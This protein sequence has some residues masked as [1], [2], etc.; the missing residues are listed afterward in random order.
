MKKLINIIVILFLSLNISAQFDTRTVSTSSGG[1]AMSGTYTIWYGNNA[2]QILKPFIICEGFDP[3]NNINAAYVRDAQ[4]GSTFCNA[5]WNAGFDVIVLNLNNNPMAIEKNADLF[6]A[7]INTINA[8]L[9]TNQSYHRLNVLGVSM[10][11]LVIR[12][13]LAKMEQQG[14]DHRVENYISFDSPQLGA[15]VPLGLQQMLDTYLGPLIDVA[16]LNS[17]LDKLDSNGLRDKME[18]LS[19][20]VIGA[21]IHNFADYTAAFEMSACYMRENVLRANFLNNLKSVGDFPHNC[22]NIAIS[23]GA[24]TVDQGFGQGTELLGFNQNYTLVNETLNLPWGLGSVGFKWTPL[25]IQNEVN[26]MKGDRLGRTF[27]ASFQVQPSLNDISIGPTYA[28]FYSQH[29]L[30]VPANDL[31]LD[32]AP[33]SYQTLQLSDMQDWL[34][35]RVTIPIDLSYKV[36]MKIPLIGFHCTTVGKKFDITFPRSKIFGT[37]TTATGTTDDTKFRFC[38]VPT[39]SALA[40][41][42]SNWFADIKSIIPT[43]PYPR[44][45]SVTPFDAICFSSTNN[46]H[47]FMPDQTDPVYNFLTTELIPDNLYIQNRT[48]NNSYS[49]VFEASAIYIGNNVDPVANRTSPGDVLANADTKISFRVPKT[50]SVTLKN[51]CDINGNAR[52]F[53]DPNYTINSY[54]PM[55]SS[56]E[57]VSL[58]SA[59]LPNGPDN[60][61]RVLNLE[62][63][64]ITTIT[65]DVNVLKSGAI[66]EK[67]DFQIS[68]TKIEVY[69]NPIIEEGKI[70]LEISKPTKVIA[71]VTSM[72]GIVVKSLIDSNYAP[73][74]YTVSFSTIDLPKGFYLCN[75]YYDG[76]CK[77]IKIV[78][79]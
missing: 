44:D 4:V 7:L 53:A 33:G 74:F 2:S 1:S 71:N 65:D 72:Q 37:L 6:I 34:N 14:I 78:V 76:T 32:N 70:Y 48:F 41:N 63:Y 3:I 59:A 43:Y 50:G 27:T 60:E 64:R 46:V 20:Q 21:N 69:P 57:S 36:C 26:A 75:V 8:E 16:E 28:N 66:S 31:R 29:D 58:K 5:L 19:V 9:T 12:Y 40:I 25:S 55:K 38:F 35:T 13:A 49:N 73:G 42:N 23:L 51:G 17:I 68:E 67:V 79:Q 62:D 47:P 30:L 56:A 11:G 18:A 22:R 52:I 61:V 45:K 39:F 24:N 54:T 10:G 77:T 15:N